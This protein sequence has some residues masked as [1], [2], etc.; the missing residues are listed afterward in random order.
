MKTP[1]MSVQRQQ[2]KVQFANAQDYLNYELGNAQRRLPSV[3]VRLLGFSICALV[4]GTIAWATFSKVDEVATAPGQVIPA[5]QVQPM[6][7]LASGLLREIK[8]AEGKHVQKGD[9]LVQLDPTISQSEVDRLEKLSQQSRDTLA[10]LQAERNGNTQ[11]GSLLQNQLLAARLREFRDRR[12]AA[13]AEANRQ[14]SIIETTQVKLSQLQSESA[15]TN[16]K[17][18]AIASLLTN[19]AVP[20]FDYLDARNK[21]D[22]LQKEIIAQKQEIEQAKQS[23]QAAINNATRLE[24]ERQSEILTQ[25]DK[26]QQ[27]LTDL[28]AQLTQAQAQHKHSTVRAGVAGTVYNIKVSKTGATVQPGDE[29]LSIVPDGEELILEAKVQNQDIGF[30]RSGM[31]VKVKLAT[32]PYQEFGMIEG[33]VSRVSP[34]AV[35]EQNG[36]LVFPVQVRLKQRSVRTSDQEVLL[37]PG[38]AATAEIVTRQKT[39][40]SFLLDP[41][42]AS[43]DRAFSVR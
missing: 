4:G 19:G 32:F 7:S 3:Y 1:S 23:Y 8:V 31:R 9:V 42:T 12:A 33:I 10:R 38:M 28:N 25:I 41:I 6:R 16:T 2:T 34:N 35:N 18:N 14:M 13:H 22:S 20:R 11:A 21:A 40:M 37:S 36:G 26:Q 27:E 5:S 43:W 17:A 30:V 39:V 24:S 15:Y 29:V